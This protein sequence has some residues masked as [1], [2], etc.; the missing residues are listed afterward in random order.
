M[1]DVANQACFFLYL[2]NFSHDQSNWSSL[3]FFRTI[4]KNFRYF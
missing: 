2:L 1:Q 3:S 4:F